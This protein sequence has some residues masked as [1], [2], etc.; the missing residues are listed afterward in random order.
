MLLILHIILLKKGRDK[1]ISLCWMRNKEVNLTY[2]L[3]DSMMEASLRANIN[4]HNV[5]SILD[6]KLTADLNIHSDC[7]NIGS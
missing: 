1:I 6:T 5:S 2:T 4:L 7:I 3:I